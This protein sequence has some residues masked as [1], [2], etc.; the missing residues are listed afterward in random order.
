MKN[1][2]RHPR[3]FVYPIFF[4]LAT[5]IL[6]EIG[7]RVWGY[8]DGYIYE[9]IYMPFGDGTSIPFIHKP[10]L[11]HA[12]ARSRTYIDTDEFGLRSIPGEKPLSTLGSSG[13]RLAFVGN[14][15][16]FGQGVAA[17]ESFPIVTARELQSRTT[18]RVL[19]ARNFGVAGY[20]VREMA[21][22]VIL[23]TD[24]VAPDAILFCAG[25]EDFDTT[26]CGGVDK[27][28]YNVN[29]KLSGDIDKDFIVKRWLRSVHLSYVLRDLRGRFLG[30]DLPDAR[31]TPDP[32]IQTVVPESYHNILL[33]RDY[34]RSR[35]VPF[36][37]VLLPSIGLH[38]EQF[39]AIVAQSKK[40]SV[41]LINLSH[42]GGL[43]AP[44]KFAVSRF[45]AHPSAV[46][47]HAIG[48]Q[49]ADALFW[50][51]VLSHI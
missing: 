45:D 40:D 51:G 34:A 11:N 43:F 37:L 7:V 42:L 21:W 29:K 13:L 33:A 16:T 2:F 38:G 25:I 41:S 18:E 30:V 23:R 10:H 31:V 4:L 22:T 36:Y 5:L 47:H 44:E 26:R 14:S 32:T 35:H 27:W 19:A 48:A 39:D 8:S 24:S 15:V 28:G 1:P 49:L 46:V 12:L 20:S 6:L 50:A 17:P 3:L 9:P